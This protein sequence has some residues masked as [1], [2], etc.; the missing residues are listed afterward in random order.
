MGTLDLLLR[1]VHGTK[2]GRHFFL[3]G[4][5]GRGINVFIYWVAPCLV[6]ARSIFALH[7][8]IGDRQLWHVGSRDRT[9]APALGAWS[10]S[11]R[12]TREVLE[13]ICPLASFQS[14][15]VESQG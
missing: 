5:R 3:C 13:G 1:I 6:R 10:L 11:H 7:C 4:G 2:Q 15:T 12:A 9:W 8:G 14:Q